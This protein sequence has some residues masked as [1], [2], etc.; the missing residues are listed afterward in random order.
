MKK[1]TPEG[2]VLRSILDYLAVN[3]VWCRRMNSGAI[4]TE[5]GGFMKFGS[6]GMADILATP[7]RWTNQAGGIITVLWIEC[8]TPGGKQSQGQRN[9]Q[10]EVTSS[11]HLYVVATSIDD[12]A[13][14][15][16]GLTYTI[17]PAEAGAIVF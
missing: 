13:A 4:R 17:A 5:G 12:V 8:K 10:E 7:I 9:F 15:L 16:E 11:G 3:R 6:V 2:Q 14:A 1:S